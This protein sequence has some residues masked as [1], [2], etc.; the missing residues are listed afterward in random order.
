VFSRVLT[1]AD[2]AFFSGFTAGDGSFQVRPNNAGASWCCELEIRLRADN[3]PLLAAFREWSGAGELFAM[4]AQGHANPQSG[5]RVTRRS[6]CERVAQLLEAYPPLGKAAAQFALWR[7]AV[8]IWGR[9]G[10]ASPELPAIAARLRMLHHSVRPVA[11]P[12]DIT[13]SEL[14]PFLSGFASAEA[15]F[16]ASQEGSP[17][18]VVNLRA[19]DAPLLALFQRTFEVGDLRGRAPAGRSREAVSWRTGRLSDLRRLVAWLDLCPPRGRAADIYT[20][21]RELVVLEPRTA[22]ARRSLAAEARRLRQFIPGLDAIDRVPR[23]ERRR[24]RA[25][26]ALR[27]WSS[28][29]DYPGSAVD[30]E[31]W[32]RASARDAPTRNTIAAAYGSWLEALEAVWARPDPLLSARARRCDS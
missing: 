3:T 6:D 31:R 30:Y 14:A 10:G 22:G 25:E 29:D 13:P 18:F 12:V 5:W 4:R 32:R 8:G 26:G 9:N 19:D 23:N 20:P 2:L 1:P 27:A 21:W 28:S 11:C 24:K 15:H 17:V 7:R 16:G